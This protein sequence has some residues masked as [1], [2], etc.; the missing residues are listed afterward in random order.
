MTT[1]P[2]SPVQTQSA[3]AEIRDVHQTSCC[4]VGGG[5]GGAMLALLL[6]RRG[7]SVTLLEMHKD[8]DR[9]FRGDTI[10]PSILEILDQIGLADKLH[11]IPHTK[12]TGPTFQFANGPFSPFNL[13]RLKTRFPYILIVPQV[14]FLEFITREAAKYP[15][16]KLIMHANVQ[17]MIEEGGVVRGV[18]YLGPDGMHEIRADLTVAADGRFSLLRRLAGIEPIKTAPP[19]DVL[20]FRLPKLPGEPEISGGVFGGIGRGRIFVLLERT[21]YWQSGLVFPKGQYQEMRAKGVEEV[22]KSI[23]EIEPRFARHAEHLTDWQQF[24]LLSVESNRCPLWHKPGLLLIGDAAHVM[25]P[26]G[27]VGINYAIQDAVVAANVLTKPLLTGSVS[28]ADLAEVQR[29]RELPTRAIQAMQSF[30][31][32]NLVANA[33]RAQQAVSIPWQLKLFVRIPILRNLPSRMIAFG[34]RRVRL[35]EP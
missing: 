32:R 9:E 15:Q 31:Q 27:G 35:V 8:F 16:F 3:D 5:P 12:A 29:Q 19:M 26:V 7:V 30:M 21:D 14:R 6:A 24:T 4:I 34:L 17:K 13:K 18:R 2:L 28:D 20:W 10:H 11:E 25:S 22:R 1:S 23:I 33:L